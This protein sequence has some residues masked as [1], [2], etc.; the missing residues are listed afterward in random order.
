MPPLFPTTSSSP[1]QGTIHL[2]LLSPSIPS[3]STLS[4]TYPLKLLPSRPHRLSS[5]E[6]HRDV[7]SSAQQDVPTG[8]AKASGTAQSTVPR[9]TLVPLLFVLTYG[10][11]LL[12]GDCIDLK[13]CLDPCTR[14]AIATQGSTKVYKTPHSSLGERQK[15]RQG[16]TTVE[17]LASDHAIQNSSNSP[18]LT[19]RQDLRV[20]IHRGAA[21]WLAP[22]PIQPF[23]GSQ[24]AQTQIFEM[25]RGASLGAVDWVSEGRRARNESWAMDGWRGRNEI[26]ATIPAKKDDAGR[27]L[28]PERKRLMVRDSVILDPDGVDGGGIAALV[29]HAGVFGTLLL[30]GPLFS[31]LSAF[32]LAE[33]RALPRLGARNWDSTNPRAAEEKAEVLSPRQRWRQERLQREHADAVLWTAA[34][35]RAGVTVVKFSAGA[36]EGARLWL[37]AMLGEEGTVARE[38]G[39]GGL[40]F[41]R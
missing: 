3:F 36:V 7:Q 37:R 38:F 23:A 32:F 34:S 35:V 14:L 28:Y 25:E 41:V 12:A 20:R 33:F 9:P 15:A 13:I 5:F 24:Y 30:H 40:I 19:S 2:T 27:E 31:P 6:L 8:S 22:D 1:G 21:L 16:N 26:W 11:G 17:T 39:E 29:A 4:Y 10:G 18:D